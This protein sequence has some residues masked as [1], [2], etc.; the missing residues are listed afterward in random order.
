VGFKK[1]DYE[2]VAWIHLAL[3]RAQWA[4]VVKTVIDFGI[5]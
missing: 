1:L 5:P 4:D 3:E 2:D